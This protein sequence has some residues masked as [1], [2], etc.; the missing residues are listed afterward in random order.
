MDIMEFLM[1]HWHIRELTGLTA[2]AQK[3]QDDV[4]GLLTKFRKLTE[5]ND[6]ILKSKATVPTAFSWIFNREVPVIQT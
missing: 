6:R 4:C 3:A 5:R 2:E 1:R